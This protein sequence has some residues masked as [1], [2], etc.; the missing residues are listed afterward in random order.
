MQRLARLVVPFR[1]NM[2][3]SRLEST[4]LFVGSYGGSLP[5]VNGKGKGVRVVHVAKK[6]VSVDPPSPLWSKTGPVNPSY[7]ALHPKLDVVYAVDEQ[8]DDGCVFAFA[9]SKDSEL[10]EISKVSSH[11]KA[12]ANLMVEPN[13]KFLLVANYDGGPLC[14]FALDSDTGAITKVSDI[15]SE[16]FAATAG[17]LG[18]HEARQDKSHPHQCYAQK[19]ADGAIHIFAC[20]LGKDYIHRFALSE[21]GKLTP[22]GGVSFPPGS[23]PRHV[24]FHPKLPHIMFVVCELTSILCTVDLSGASPHIASGFLST[25]DGCA[26][27]TPDS[28]STA[29]AI[30]VHPSGDFVYCSNRIAGSSYGSFSQFRFNNGSLSFESC[31]SSH[32]SCPREL[33]VDP[34]GER[35]FLCNQGGTELPGD[36]VGSIVCFSLDAKTGRPG[37]EPV[38]I[39]RTCATPVAL[40]IRSHAC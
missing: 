9:V 5:H 38:F 33:K 16:C 25:L 40:A 28:T 32:G 7:V 29:A 26:Q 34:N 37:V 15:A 13:G 30:D 3:H 20:D 10:S 36:E 8:E 2:S 35:I 17:S 31:F 23:G 18:P 27:P 22:L 14:S 19:Q 1:R 24:T 21:H 4:T 11:G 39:E 12:C 6:D